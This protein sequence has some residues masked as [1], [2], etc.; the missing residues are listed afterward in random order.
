MNRRAFLALFGCGVVGLATDWSGALSGLVSSQQQR[1][2]SMA[3]EEVMLIGDRLVAPEMSAFMV[4]GTPFLSMGIRPGEIFRW[5]AMPES[6]ILIR[7]QDQDVFLDGRQARAID[8]QFLWRLNDKCASVTGCEYC[9]RAFYTWPVGGNCLSCGGA[10]PA[11][12]I[13]GSRF[14]TTVKDGKREVISLA[15]LQQSDDK[16]CEYC[17]AQTVDDECFS[18]GAR[19]IA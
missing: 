2:G 1:L 14:L 15:Q 4:R 9:G 10:L 7:E 3:I 5:V 8:W 6:E 13:G 18:C 16:A 17:G 11:P 19:V 12:L